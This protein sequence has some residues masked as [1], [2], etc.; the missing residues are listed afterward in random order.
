MRFY[1]ILFAVV[2][3][4]S[5]PAHAATELKFAVKQNQ[6]LDELSFY[7]RDHQV[8]IGQAASARNG[9]L[10]N[11]KDHS[12][13][14]LDHAR[15]TFTRLDQASLS[16]MAQMVQSVGELAKVQGGILGDLFE[17]LGLESDLG[18][19]NEIVYTD[20]NETIKIGGL[21][22]Q[23]MEVS[24]DSVLQTRMCVTDTLPLSS[25]EADTLRSL[26]QFG[27]RVADQ[28]GG[29]IQKFGVTIPTLPQES[30]ENF[31]IGV[32]TFDENKINARLTEIKAAQLLDEDFSVPSDY[33][34]KTL[35]I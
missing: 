31:I 6:Q 16:Q 11:A 13:L 1:S 29:L 21:D 14:I 22:C 26:I 33:Q 15:K 32:D 23:V 30:F 9:V 12:L 4:L 10:F 18:K 20:K 27:Q 8:L 24:K 5:A 7:V 35:P 19:K 28:A 2:I 34:E 17:S 25:L 3:T